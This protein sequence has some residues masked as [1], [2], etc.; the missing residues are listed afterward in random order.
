MSSSLLAVDPGRDTGLAHFED[1]ELRWCTLARSFS[2]T[3]ARLVVIEEPQAY[4]HT[5]TPPQALIRLA[6]VVGQYQEMA[7]RAGAEVKLVKPRQWKGQLPK[8]ICNKRVVEQLTCEERA[9][10]YPSLTAIAR[11]KRHNVIDAIGIGLWELGRF[12]C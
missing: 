12:R 3:T 7:R 9:L 10:A 2:A 6:E 5:P 4:R 8:D 11:G 1:G